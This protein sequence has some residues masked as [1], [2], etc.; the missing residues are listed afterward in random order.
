MGSKNYLDPVGN[1]ASV[2]PFERYPV[3]VNGYLVPDLQALDHGEFVEIILDAR[4]AIDV[5]HEYA[6]RVIW[7]MSNII[8][9]GRGHACHPGPD[10]WTPE[11]QPNGVPPAY[12]KL[13]PFPGAAEEAPA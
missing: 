5:P 7:M 12:T 4:W 1:V 2:G 11:P 10:T 9:M 3:T 8:A 6:S 13:L